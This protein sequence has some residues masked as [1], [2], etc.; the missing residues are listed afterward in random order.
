MLKSESSLKS[1]F[2]FKVKQPTIL[3]WMATNLSSPEKDLL[4][5]L[6]TSHC[7]EG[8]LQQSCPWT[9]QG[10]PRYRDLWQERRIETWIR[11]RPRSWPRSFRTCLSRTGESVSHTL[12]TRIHSY[13]GSVNSA[14]RLLKAPLV[15]KKWAQAASSASQMWESCFLSLRDRPDYFKVR[16]SSRALIANAFINSAVQA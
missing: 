8:R 1:R 3:L 2:E 10:A 14:C 13:G 7:R 5:G 11:F 6:I 4:V 16:S 15:C 9:G 12:L